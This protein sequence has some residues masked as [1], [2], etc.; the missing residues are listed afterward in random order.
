MTRPTTRRVPAATAAVGVL[1]VL[2]AGCGGS[3]PTAVPA[4]LTTSTAGTAATGG[5]ATG[6]AA[7][8]PGTTGPAGAWTG[9]SVIEPPLRAGHVIVAVG[10]GDGQHAGDNNDLSGVTV[11]VRGVDPTTGRVRWAHPL[12]AF[13]DH[14]VPSRGVPPVDMAADPTGGSPL[15]VVAYDQTHPQSG[16]LTTPDTPTLLALDTTTGAVAWTVTGTAAI[17]VA[18]DRRTVLVSVRDTDRA[19][20]P[21]ALG[22]DAATGKTL[23]TGTLKGELRLAGGRALG[24]DADGQLTALDERTGRP[25][26]TGPSEGL[27]GV[28]PAG[29]LGSAATS[30]S[31]GRGDTYNV[32]L[33]DP[34]TGKVTA[35]S[36]DVGKGGFTP[37][38]TFVDPITGT[39]VLEGASG[40]DAP[41]VLALAA[42]DLHVA[43]TVPGSRIPDMTPTSSPRPARSCSPTRTRGGPSWTTGPASRCPYRRTTR[44]PSWST[45]S[46][47][48]PTPV[49]A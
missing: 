31:S 42:P 27:V 49:Q 10:I 40:P 38:R 8:T 36:P 23:W 18:V 44:Q 41:G 13:T 24:D 30:H 16:A 35:R 14:E 26:W 22:L 21:K 7:G 32:V 39:V 9:P 25:A 43:W 45:G 20:S 17:P 33:H 29:V 46:R 5:P 34:V 37:D 47:S 15:V 2:A 1:A 28:V 48:A 4:P 19:A 12:P 3:A 11:V 6:P